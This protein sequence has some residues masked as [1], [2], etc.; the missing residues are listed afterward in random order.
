MS[1]SKVLA[2]LDCKCGNKL[3]KFYMKLFSK[4]CVLLIVNF[5]FCSNNKAQNVEIYKCCE[6]LKPAIIVLAN[7]QD[8]EKILTQ[9]SQII[10]KNNLKIHV[11]CV[12]NTKVTVAEISGNINQI[13][14]KEFWFFKQAIHLLAIG[15]TA[16]ENYFNSIDKSVFGHT[17]FA[18]SANADTLNYSK[19]VNTCLQKE[20]FA[21]QIEQLE[22]KTKRELFQKNNWRFGII[23][24]FNFQNQYTVDSAYI[25]STIF[26]YGLA[27]NWQINPHW[28]IMGRLLFSFKIPSQSK[29]QQEMQSKIRI[30][31]G[32]QTVSLQIAIGIYTQAALQA[33]YSFNLKHKLKPYI[34][35]GLNSFTNMSG[36]TTV[37][38]SINPASMQGGGMPN[39]GNLNN[40]D[41]IDMLEITTANLTLSSGFTYPLTPKTNIVFSIDY[42]AIRLNTTSNKPVSNTVLN[43]SF[44]FGFLFKFG[45]KPQVV[46][47]Y[48]KAK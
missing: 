24:G 36:R 2:K 25:P 11:A 10:Q 31:G 6:E 38:Q 4:T 9:L 27:T 18:S 26:K 8:K 46:Y 47:D 20:V 45:K 13:L 33:N 37:T 1:I 3:A 7:K 41:D 29:I 39:L 28:S 34:G 40:R 42:D 30:D 32:V 5:I 48:V 17:Y 43:A 12:T 21:L 44:Q 16:V 14:N 23:S 22:E 19:F 35:I 15:D